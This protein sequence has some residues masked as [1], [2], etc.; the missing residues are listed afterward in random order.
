[1]KVKLLKLGLLKILNSFKNIFFFR[2]KKESKL[3]SDY[4]LAIS[5]LENKE[6]SKGIS[7]LREILQNNI[8][9]NEESSELKYCI[10]ISLGTAYKQESLFNEALHY[11][12]KATKLNPSDFKTFFEM[13]NICLNEVGLNFCYK[14]F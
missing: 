3:Y 7:L 8:I 10:Y 12:Y 9:T 4:E 6:I 14:V 11:F 13:A 2:E 5:Y 1:M